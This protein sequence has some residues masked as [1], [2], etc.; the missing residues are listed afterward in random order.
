MGELGSVKEKV[1]GVAAHVGKQ[2]DIER[3]IAEAEAKFGP[4]NVLINNAGT[5]PYF[6]PIVDSDERAGTKRSKSISRARTSSPAS[7]PRK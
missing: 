1:H 7:W 3:L 4:V 2:E 5:N 6:G